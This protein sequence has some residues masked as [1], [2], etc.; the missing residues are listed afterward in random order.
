MFAARL[1]F[2][3]TKLYDFVARIRTSSFWQPWQVWIAEKV[4]E[5]CNTSHLIDNLIGPIAIY[6]NSSQE[7]ELYIVCNRIDFWRREY[8][9]KILLYINLPK[10]KTSP[11]D[12]FIDTTIVKNI[13]GNTNNQWEHP[14][15]KSEAK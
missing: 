11:D 10:P 13:V 2:L 9:D 12:V 7:R 14:T 5:Y 6:T 15:T 4:I 3:W 1:C 8:E